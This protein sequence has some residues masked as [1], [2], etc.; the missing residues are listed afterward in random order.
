MNQ[1]Q[2]KL[3]RSNKTIFS[4]AYQSDLDHAYAFYCARYANI[5]WEEFLQLGFLEFKKK[6]GSIPKDEPLYEIIKSRTIKISAIKEKE[7]RKYWKELK[8]I[9]EIPP[10]YIPSYELDKKLKEATNNGKRFS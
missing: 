1:Y 6:L 2:L 7:E 4:F 10:I 8:R 5:T 3:S 9:N